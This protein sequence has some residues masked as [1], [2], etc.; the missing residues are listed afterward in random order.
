MSVVLRESSI[1]QIVNELAIRSRDS[2]GDFYLAIVGA[3]G[4]GLDEFS[5]LARD[6][7]RKIL[8]DILVQTSVLTPEI[9]ES[10]A[11]TEQ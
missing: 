11:I 5:N 4:K 1:E 3:G 2:G 7:K 8:T 9:S 6:G 10:H